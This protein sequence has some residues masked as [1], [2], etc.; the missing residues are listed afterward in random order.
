MK[1]LDYIWERAGIFE[2]RRLSRLPDCCVLE[3]FFSPMI[4]ADKNPNTNTFRICKCLQAAL[5]SSLLLRLLSTYFLP[6]FFSSLYSPLAFLFVH[7]CKLSGVQRVTKDE[8][9]QLF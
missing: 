5:P 3:I 7:F 9:I 4:S 1:W 6:V 8:I 2:L